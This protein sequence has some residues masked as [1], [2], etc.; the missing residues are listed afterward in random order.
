MRKWIGSWIVVWG[1]AGIGACGGK[2]DAGPGRAGAA[3]GAGG[4]SASA[5]AEPKSL[6]LSNGL[7][8]TAP[9]DAKESAMGKMLSVVALGGK[10]QAMIGEVSDMS[11]SFEN[12]LHN[13]EAGNMG[14]PLKEMKRKE[15]KGPDDFVIEWTTEKKLGYA[16]RRTAQGKKWYC[17]RVSSD[18]AGHACVVAICESIK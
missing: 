5:S 9:G 18:P 17:D 4:E 7:T 8:V 16:S 15:S 1:V 12:Q 3:A 2:S 10:C 6:T 14:G 13:I 11:P